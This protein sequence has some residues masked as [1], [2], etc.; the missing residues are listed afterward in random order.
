MGPHF[1]SV[2]E[3]FFCRP[4][5]KILKG[6]VNLVFEPSC[7]QRE[8]IYDSL[9]LSEDCFAKKPSVFGILLFFSGQ[10]KIAELCV[11]LT[12]EVIYQ[13]LHFWSIDL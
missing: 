5:R 10:W 11:G 12:K 2:A 3:Y 1:S 13:I 8:L 6:F 9:L 4:G 7:R